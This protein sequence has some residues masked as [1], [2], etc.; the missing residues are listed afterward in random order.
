MAGGGPLDI[1][2]GRISS[3]GRLAEVVRGSR[4]GAVLWFHSRPRLCKVLGRTI[5]L[6]AAQALRLWLSVA[7]VG[8][9]T[10]LGNM[11]TI[12]AMAA[13]AF[14]LALTFGNKGLK[15]GAIV[16]SASVLGIDPDLALLA[17]LIDR[18]ASLLMTFV[19]GLA[20][21]QYL[22]RRATTEA[23]PTP[24]LRKTRQGESQTER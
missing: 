7:A 13:V 1:L 17:S 5:V 22:I 10:D 24:D 11:L 6:F 19:T 14:V 2:S 8:I 9:A 4:S 21:D 20:S 12:Q 3:E 23:E 16:F 18:A 15:E